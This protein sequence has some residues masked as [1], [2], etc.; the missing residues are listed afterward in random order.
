MFISSIFVLFLQLSGEVNSRT[1]AW[2]KNL[3]PMGGTDQL[4]KGG[5]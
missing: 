1:L 5:S 4:S 3:L 2:K